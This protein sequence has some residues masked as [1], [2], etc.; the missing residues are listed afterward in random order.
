[1][2]SFKVNY[3]PTSQCQTNEVIS[4]VYQ[5]LWHVSTILH[6]WVW[7]SHVHHGQIDE[8]VAKNHLGSTINVVKMYRENGIVDFTVQNLLQ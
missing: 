7:W 4:H 8:D 2:L 6:L 1:M 3:H 5:I